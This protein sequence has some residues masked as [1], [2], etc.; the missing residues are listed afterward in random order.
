MLI[1]L[2][3]LAIYFC[4]DAFFDLVLDSPERSSYEDYLAEGLEI[5]EKELTTADG[6]Q[7]RV[8]ILENPKLLDS[9]LP[10]VYLQHGFGAMGPSW[11]LNKEESAPAILCKAG[12][13]VYV[14]NGRGSA[15]SHGHSRYTIHDAE[16]WDFTFEDVVYDMVALVDYIYEIHQQKVVYVGHSQGGLTGL[17]ALSDDRFKS[18]FE[19]RILKVYSLTPVVCMK[20]QSSINLVIGL[21][22]YD[23]AMSLRHKMTYVGKTRLPENAWQSFKEQLLNKICGLNHRICF[24]G[25]WAS[26]VSNAFNKMDGFGTWERFHPSSVPF[27]G[28][29]HFL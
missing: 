14:L 15:L 5:T 27:K 28:C 7:I 29:L 18:H 3:L 19:E 2:T 13:K 1:A 6:Y 23:Y 24:W 21:K 9:S 26:D 17:T 8:L 10:P 20:G 16:Y 11:L 22:M 25:F 12:H 4:T